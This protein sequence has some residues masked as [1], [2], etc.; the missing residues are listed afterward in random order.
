MQAA[1]DI[2]FY[3]SQHM[4]L[5]PL[6]NRCRSGTFA[7]LPCMAMLGLLGAPVSHAQELEPR[8]YSASPVGANFLV[9]NYTR[10]TGEVLTDPSLP[11]TDI[12]AEINLGTLGYV[13]TFGLAGR[14]ASLGILVPVAQ[15]DV[16]GNVYDAPREVHR[17]GL[18]DVRMRFAMGLIGAPALSPQEFARREPNASLG[19]SLTVIAPTGR[20]EPSRLIN[21]GS[22]RW[23]FKPEIGLSKPFGNWFVEATAGVWLY[24]ENSEFLGSQR[25][26]Q[27]PLSV[28][29]LHGGY[30]FSPGLW[31]AADAGV[32]SGGRTK[33]NGV[34]GQDRQEN[35][36]FGL[37]LSVPLER[38]WSVKLSWA[39]GL[40][41]RAAGDFTSVSVTLQY[42]WFSD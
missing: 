26:K 23:A 39:K 19:A 35:S 33:L 3:S 27:E 5:M 30:T 11:I 36:R 29:Q 4:P 17:G 34:P 8:A 12:D 31:L 2:A 14:S 24:T 9:A 40:A 21:V 10:L 41:T 16:S 28:I 13:R 42:H 1:L 22:N 7:F 20:Y 18:G 6:M 15:A 37:T 25:R 38:D 32:Y